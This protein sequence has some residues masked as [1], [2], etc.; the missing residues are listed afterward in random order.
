MTPFRHRLA[1]GA[2]AV[3]ALAVVAACS[4]ADGPSTRLPAE[5]VTGPSATRIAVIGD[6]GSGKQGEREL[7][8]AV[9]SDDERARFAALITT[10]D[11]VYPSGDPADFDGAWTVPYGWV[12][13]DGIPV[14]A[15]LGNHDRKSGKQEQVMNLLGMPG[16]WYS[17]QVGDVQVIVLDANDVENPEQLR[18]LDDVLAEPRG[19]GVDWRIVVFHQPAFS[20][21]RH[22][23]TPAVQRAWVSSFSRSDVDLV[24]NGHDHVYQR[25]APIS[26]VTYVVTGGAGDSLY[27]M[28]DCPKGTPDPVVAAVRRHYVVLE[29]SADQL[30]IEAVTGQGALLDSAVLPH[31]D[32]RRT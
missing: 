3:L 31:R 17:R 11:N 24:L 26:G 6:F 29:A 14:L 10:G 28:R 25:F 7:A 21:S 20:C 19:P 23:S 12:D 32:A 27:E 9:R 8:S 18:F 2:G 4:P 16:R 1:A 5:L 30:R 15:S 13:G 22:Q